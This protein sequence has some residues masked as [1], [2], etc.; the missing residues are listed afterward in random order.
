MRIGPWCKPL[1][2]QS[3]LHDAHSAQ[4]DY[5]WTSLAA[6]YCLTLTYSTIEP[7]Q[8]CQTYN[9]NVSISPLIF[10]ISFVGAERAIENA[11]QQQS[12]TTVQKLKDFRWKIKPA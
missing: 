1:V 8:C 7:K 12:L 4:T 11:I 3:H 10:L 5:T 6:C 2:E 9:E